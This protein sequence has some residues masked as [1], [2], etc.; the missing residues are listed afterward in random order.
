VLDRLARC[1]P[2]EMRRLLVN[3]FGNARL[4]CRDEIIADDVDNDRSAKKSRIGF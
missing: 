4:N 1:A 2:R 3:G